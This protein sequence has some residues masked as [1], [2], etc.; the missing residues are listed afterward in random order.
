MKKITIGILS[1]LCLEAQ[2]SANNLATS[3]NNDCAYLSVM[4][5]NNTDSNCELTSKNVLHGNMSSGTQVPLL[6]QAHTSTHPFSMRQTTYGPDIVLTYQCGPEAQIT[7]ESQQN[8]CYF[9]AGTITGTVY[10]HQQLTADYT[11][12]EGSAWWGRHG[13]ISWKLFQ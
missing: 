8:V 6:I 3:D 13:A 1:L 7:F 11:K 10:A 5:S 12:E 9:T 2:A 4:I